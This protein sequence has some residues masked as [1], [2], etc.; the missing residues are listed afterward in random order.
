MSTT[1]SK[2]HTGTLH[3]EQ[4]PNT[5]NKAGHSV[6]TNPNTQNKAG[7]LANGIL[8]NTGTDQGPGFNT[9]FT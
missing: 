8:D 2:N 4:N 9:V 6:H 3:Q 5:Q 1:L 7:L